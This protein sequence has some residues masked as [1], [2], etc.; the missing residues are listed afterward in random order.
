MPGNN[1]SYTFDRPIMHLKLRGDTLMISDDR[2][3]VHL[4]KII[5]AKKQLIYIGGEDKGRNVVDCNRLSDN[6]YYVVDTNKT[7]SV[8]TDKKISYTSYDEKT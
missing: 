3:S 6:L 8:F 2:N 4:Y 5:T 7:L 1:K